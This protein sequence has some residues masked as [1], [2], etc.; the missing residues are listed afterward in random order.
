MLIRTLILTIILFLGLFTSYEDIKTGKIRNIW[1]ISGF[2]IAIFMIFLSQSNIKIVVSNFLISAFLAYKFWDFRLWSP[3]DAKLFIVY[4][5]LLPVDRYSRCYFNFFP[6]F[7][8]LLNIF[9][10]PT[11]FLILKAINHLRDKAQALAALNKLNDAIGDRQAH[12]LRVVSGFTLIFLAT[13]IARQELTGLIAK[14]IPQGNI[15]F[16][17][18]FLVYPSLSNIFKNKRLLIFLAYVFF[19]VFFIL[20][21]DITSR[22][23][24]TLAR[25]LKMTIA[26]MLLTYICRKS[27]DLYIEA[28]QSKTLPF[29]VWMLLGAL[30]TFF[31]NL[32]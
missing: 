13:Q 26:L 6:A 30:I 14:F 5:L 17:I 11:A 3:G 25:S 8:L 27:T 22:L 20:Q 24:V 18:S 21:I 23:I 15:V 29:A 9:I 12:F 28:S 4:A 31:Y 10:P 1:I 16:A 2:L 32:N 7:N 19:V